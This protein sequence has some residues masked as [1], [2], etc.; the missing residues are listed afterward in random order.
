MCHSACATPPIQLAEG[1]QSQYYEDPEYGVKYIPQLKGMGA[2]W[3]GKLLTPL[4]IRVSTNSTMKR[5][6]CFGEELGV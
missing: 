5:L 6:P 4:G 1:M 2:L 3:A